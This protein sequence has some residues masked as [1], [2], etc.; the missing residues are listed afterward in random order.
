MIRKSLTV[1][2]ALAF[3]SC[4]FYFSPFTNQS[5]YEVI[6][7][8]IFG[9]YYKVT[10]KANEQLDLSKTEVQLQVEAELK[11]IDLIASSWK[12][13]S[14]LSRF[15]QSGAS[16]DFPLS[17]DLKEIFELSDEIKAFTNGAFNINYQKNLFDLSGI[18]KGYAVDKVA[19]YL[20]AAFN[21]DAYLVDIGGEVKARGKN[22]KGKTW[23]ATIYIPPAYSSIKSPKVVLLNT[24]IATSGVYFKQDHIKN[25]GTEDA[26]SN[27]LLSSSV[28][29]PSNAQADALAT[30]LYVMGSEKGWHWVREN[31][32]QAIFIKNDGT[33]L[34]SR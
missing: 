13:E 23:T 21:I 5:H 12:P 26:V 7:G 1:L 22:A 3:L 19:A 31:N 2:S 17:I 24:S 28:I 34:D 33:V 8:K 11:R 18:A 14:E 25:P 15:N 6:Q 10:Y 16:G 32:V 4:L 30:A 27:D 9:T 29:H 20:E